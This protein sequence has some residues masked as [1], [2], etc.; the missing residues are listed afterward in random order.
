MNRMQKMIKLARAV[1]NSEVLNSS[2]ELDSPTGSYRESPGRSASFTRKM[3]TRKPPDDGFDYPLTPTSTPVAAVQGQ[4][5]ERRSSEGSTVQKRGRRNGRERKSDRQHWSGRQHSNLESNSMPFDQFVGDTQDSGSL[6][7]KQQARLIRGE[8]MIS[9]D[10]PVERKSP[11]SKD[12]RPRVVKMGDPG[13]SSIQV[14]DRVV[15][16]PPKRSSGLFHFCFK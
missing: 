4:T 6:H 14:N 12:N 2:Q 11:S 10:I 1:S 9:V 13:T 5:T 3:A 7:W 15:I 8:P 16:R